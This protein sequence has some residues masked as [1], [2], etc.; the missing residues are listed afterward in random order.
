MHCTVLKTTKTHNI[1]MLLQVLIFLIFITAPYVSLFLHPTGRSGSSFQP[2]LLLV[3]KFGFLLLWA[4]VET[5]HTD[6]QL[7]LLSGQYGHFRLQGCVDL[8]SPASLP[9]CNS[10]LCLRWSKHI[11]Y[12]AFLTEAAGPR[13]WPLGV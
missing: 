13:A 5:T 9:A 7:I 8:F 1:L 12:P 2:S 4:I 6:A 11:H 10:P 3:A